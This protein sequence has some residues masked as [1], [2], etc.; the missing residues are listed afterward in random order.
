MPGDHWSQAS[1]RTRTNALGDPVFG[2]VGGVAL[3]L[4]ECGSGS[5]RGECEGEEAARVFAVAADD[6]DIAVRGEL[7]EC[8]GVAVAGR[9]RRTLCKTHSRSGS[10]WWLSDGWRCAAV[11]HGEVGVMG[12]WCG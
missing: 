4:G 3:V 9:C 11:R 5:S 2:S 10:G 6:R 7:L 8:D 12:C 1:S